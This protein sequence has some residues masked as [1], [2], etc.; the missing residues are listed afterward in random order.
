MLIERSLNM[1][2]N[3]EGRLKHMETIFCT[4][5]ST[6]VIPL[7]KG[8]WQTHPTPTQ[9]CCGFASPLCPAHGPQPHGRTVQCRSACRNT[10][11]TTTSSR[12]WR[13]LS[14]PRV[15]TEEAAG[16]QDM[17]TQRMETA[18][19]AA[20]TSKA[21]ASPAAVTRA[22]RANQTFLSLQPAAVMPLALC[23]SPSATLPP[24]SASASS[25][26][27]ADAVR[28][29]LYVPKDF[30]WCWLSLH[31]VVEVSFPIPCLPVGSGV[32]FHQRRKWYLFCAWDVI[33][34]AVTLFGEYEVHLVLPRECLHPG[35]G[36]LRGLPLVM[37][38][39]SSLCIHG[40]GSCPQMRK[41]A[42]AES[43]KVSFIQSLK[44]SWDSFKAFP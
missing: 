10:W 17:S 25:S 5:I 40:L 31:V 8:C 43:L 18:C 14:P 33:S 34:C 9:A 19:R 28:N 41:A 7:S 32:A 39:L 36:Q 13:S 3:W 44:L 1:H 16:C 21:N 27:Q 42:G 15:P 24:A 4:K 37:S 29:A 6:R 22:S 26:P 38:P 11:Q 30:C 35:M 20:A 23:L 2:F 12:C